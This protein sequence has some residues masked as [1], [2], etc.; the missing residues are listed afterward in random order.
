MTRPKTTIKLTGSH[1]FWQNYHNSGQFPTSSISVLA[2]MLVK[3]GDD[4]SLIVNLIKHLFGK[5]GERYTLQKGKHP[6]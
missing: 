6:V 2:S 3:P 4:F 5:I 1:N